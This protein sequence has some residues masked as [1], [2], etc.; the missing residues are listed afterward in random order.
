LQRCFLR[1]RRL[2]EIGFGNGSFLALSKSCGWQAEGLDPDVQAVANAAQRGL[3]VHHG[4][5]EYFD[6]QSA[7]FDFITM[8]H[9]LEHVH[10]PAAVLRA[11]HRLLRPGGMISIETPNI[12]AQGYR[13]FGTDWRGLEAP[14]HLIL[15]NR[16]SL[17][18]ALRD[19]GFT[20]TR[21]SR[22]P[23]ACPGM[24]KASYQLQHERAPE[25]ARLAPLP[26][27]IR[28]L[29]ATMVEVMRPDKREFLAMTA[30]KAHP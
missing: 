20:S 17:C 30:S 14:R 19:A 21:D 29:L 23:S 25:E 7:L 18:R 28:A 2:L 8:N 22:R 26:V 4:G 3:T 15:F 27:R 6:G 10:D 9:V 12:D 24:F 5:V 1:G 16:S 11:C 13:A